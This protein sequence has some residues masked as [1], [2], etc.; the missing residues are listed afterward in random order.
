[1]PYLRESG[2][3]RADERVPLVR[4]CAGSDCSSA[5]LG[6]LSSAAD[7]TSSVAFSATGLSGIRA[8]ARSVQLS[9]L[10]MFSFSFSPKAGRE[11]LER[12][13]TS[14]IAYS[15]SPRTCS[16]HSPGLSMFSGGHDVWVP[17]VKGKEPSS[18]LS[19]GVGIGRLHTLRRKVIDCL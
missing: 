15:K 6:G 17:D 18:M 7:C 4:I 1:M 8:S 12:V 19:R 10:E 14:A 9:M 11:G 16:V 5:V 3:S 2:R 13:A